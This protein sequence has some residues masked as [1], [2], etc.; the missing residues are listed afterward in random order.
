M[1]VRAESEVEL[2]GLRA[3]QERRPLLAGV[4]DH[5]IVAEVAVPQRDPPAAIA[6]R[7]GFD[8]ARTAIVTV[9]T[10]VSRHPGQLVLVRRH[11]GTGHP[12]G[13][14]FVNAVITS[15]DSRGPRAS[16]HSP[17]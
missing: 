10:D 11:A 9:R 14:S 4:D 2:A 3:R 13:Y 17:S 15:I 1:S 8:A 16:L 12:H 7:P 6:E 5:R